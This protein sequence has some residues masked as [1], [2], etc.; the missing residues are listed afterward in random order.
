MAV[1][2]PQKNTYYRLYS[3]NRCGNPGELPLPLAGLHPPPPPCVF[4]PL[5]GLLERP[6]V[7]LCAYRLQVFPLDI[8]SRD[9][10][11]HDYSKFW[12]TPPRSDVCC[13]I[14]S[15]SLNASLFLSHQEYFG[16]A[17]NALCSFSTW[18]TWTGT[19]NSS[20]IA[21]LCTRK[22]HWGLLTSSLKLL[23]ISL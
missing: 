3:I 22:C 4:P 6:C 16:S 10:S 15:L 19:P 12:T 13:S 2:E 7:S 18:S 14:F 17:G 1:L 11:V 23:Y 9:F 8:E 5:G 21:F 20:N